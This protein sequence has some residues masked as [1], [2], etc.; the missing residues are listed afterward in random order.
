MAASSELPGY[1][2][3]VAPVMTS[4]TSEEGYIF[5][6]RMPRGIAAGTNELKMTGDV[7][8]REEDEGRRPD[9]GVLEKV[10]R[11]FSRDV[12]RS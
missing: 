9:V 7:Q 2:D 1:G 10:S 4:V 11:S 6:G 3:P 12:S 5:R 8:G